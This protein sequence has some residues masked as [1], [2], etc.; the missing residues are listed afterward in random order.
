[1]RYV[2]TKI[3]QYTETVEVEAGS[4]KSAIEQAMATDGERNNDD[5]LYDAYASENKE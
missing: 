3:Y 5:H 2:V 1:M 4:K